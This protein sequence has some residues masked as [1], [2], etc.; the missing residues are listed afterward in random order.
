MTA[1]LLKSF[2][3]DVTI[4]VEFMVCVYFVGIFAVLQSDL[5]LIVLNLVVITSIEKRACKFLIHRV[6][7]WSRPTTYLDLKSTDTPSK[8]LEMVYEFFLAS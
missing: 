6:K 4:L 5:Y 2:Y 3:L 7:H 1:F 8:T